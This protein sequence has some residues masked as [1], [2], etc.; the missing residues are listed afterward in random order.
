MFLS[1]IDLDNPNDLKKL[2]DCPDIDKEYI[3]VRKTH[4]STSDEFLKE[5]SDPACL[6]R[7]KI[8]DV[9]SCKL[10]I[11]NIRPYS[12][13]IIGAIHPFFEIVGISKLPIEEIS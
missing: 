2:Y 8:N 10:N 13:E 11:Y 4:K 6:K 3:I 9:C 12:F 1:K 5:C 7:E